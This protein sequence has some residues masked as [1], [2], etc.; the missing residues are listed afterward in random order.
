MNFFAHTCIAA[1]HS[2][3]PRFLLGA[4]L[5]DLTG[6]IG[7]RIADVLD[8]TLRAGV[9]HH[10]EADS[11]F[12]GA[13]TFNAMCSEGILT[14]CAQGVER[15]TA[16]AVAHVG[17]ELLLDGVLCEDTHACERY[18]DALH[19][20]DGVRFSD[21]L[22]L[23]HQDDLPGLQRGIAQLA[24][25]PVPEGYRDLEFV[26]ARLR[27]V[28]S[29]RPRLA[30]RDSDL[31]PVLDWLRGARTRL[32]EEHPRLLAQVHSALQTGR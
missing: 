12:H 10:H 17:T 31:P 13:P 11:A 30:M 15:G 24:S 19:I 2:E 21:L 18:R 16:R 32:Q 29:R 8:D 28:L 26:A 1:S 22:A 3:H 27:H 14:L 23:R 9:A 20:G 5:P 25:A 4:M 7:V 6:M